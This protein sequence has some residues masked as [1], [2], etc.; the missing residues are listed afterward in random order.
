[1]RNAVEGAARTDQGLRKWVMRPSCF[2]VYK[3]YASLKIH[4]WETQFRLSKSSCQQVIPI[5]SA[6]LLR[7]ARTRVRI[8]SGHCTQVPNVSPMP[9]PPFLPPPALDHVHKFPTLEVAYD[10]VALH[11]YLKQV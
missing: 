7:L 10:W 6:R 9:S 2:I 3:G 4:N 11:V 8:E 1:M 5:L